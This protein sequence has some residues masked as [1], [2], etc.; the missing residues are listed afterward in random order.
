MVIIVDDRHV[1][2]V[3]AV[4][5]AR[6][7]EIPPAFSRHDDIVVV[8]IIVG[9]TMVDGRFASTHFEVML[10]DGAGCAAA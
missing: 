10:G 4:I 5:C 7:E 2:A 1:D 8:I 3:S 9:V 6:T